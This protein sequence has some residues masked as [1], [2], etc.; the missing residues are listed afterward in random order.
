MR[1][2]VD[3]RHALRRRVRAGVRHRGRGRAAGRAD[4]A[5][6]HCSPPAAVPSARSTARASASDRSRRRQSGPA[7]VPARGPLTV[8]D[9]NVMVGKLDPELFPGSSARRGTRRSTRAIVRAKFGALAA[10]V[11]ARTGRARTAEEV[12]AGFLEIAVENM[13][14]AIKHISVQRGYDVTG[15]HAVLLRRRRRPA[16]LPRRRRAVGMTRV[17]LHPFAGVL[18]AYGWAGRRAGAEQ[19]AV[20]RGSAAMRWAAIAPA[21]AAGDG[22]AGRGRGAGNSFDRIDAKRTLRSST[23]APTRRFRFRG[24]S[25][26]GSGATRDGPARRRP[27]SPTSSSA[28]AAQYGFL[29]PD[30]PLV[31][32]AVASR[33]DRGRTQTAGECGPPRLRRGAERSRRSV[34]SHLHRRAFHAAAVYDRDHLRPGD[35][36]DGPGRDPRGQRDHRGRARPGARR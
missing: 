20:E 29:M 21:L 32:E 1:R 17:L 9:C 34:E 19:Q 3:R 26:R 11:T 10:D 22:G 15:I 33:G 7:S 23:R 25:G 6:P 14:N 13:A 16:R 35:R 36:L 4:D 12:A 31:I 5:H 18:S 2:H 27:S 8:T 28:I 24:R 30:K